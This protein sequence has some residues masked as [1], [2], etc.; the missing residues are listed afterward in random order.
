MTL[1]VAENSG[2]GIV[3]FEAAN[4]AEAAAR[5]AD[6]ALLRD[7]RVL[8]NQGRSVWDGVSKIRLRQPDATEVE[9]WRS[10]H[11]ASQPSTSDDDRS[12]R[13]FLIAVVDPSEF[14]DDHDYDGPG[15]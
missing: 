13:V 5:L 14:D 9:I 4:D 8:Q 10:R 3:A 15:D 7:L 1:Y 12:W 6:K 2:R 11:A